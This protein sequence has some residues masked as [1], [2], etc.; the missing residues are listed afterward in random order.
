MHLGAKDAFF[1]KIIKFWFN[2]LQTKWEM[3]CLPLPLA[4]HTKTI[5][6]EFAVYNVSSACG[7]CIT[8]CLL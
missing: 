2:S 3:P 7:Y 8:Y 4:S 6:Q 1:Y 5:P